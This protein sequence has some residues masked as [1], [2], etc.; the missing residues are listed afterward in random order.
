M[1]SE[2]F[3]RI[4]E[5][6]R[7]CELGESY[8]VDATQ[9]G[10]WGRYRER[11]TCCIRNDG[12]GGHEGYGSKAIQEFR[13][14]K[15]PSIGRVVASEWLYLLERPVIGLP[16]LSCLLSRHRNR[17]KGE[18]L[19]VLEALTLS[20]SYLEF[21]SPLVG[22]RNLGVEEKRGCQDVGKTI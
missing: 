12:V 7:G 11:I 19:S 15:R 1:K 3:T 22:K 13:G 14:W 6:K 21:P 4:G 17:F 8:R 18:L 2:L 20:P 10:I 5:T 16:S 9:H